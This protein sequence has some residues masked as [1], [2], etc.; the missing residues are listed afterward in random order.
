MILLL[1]GAFGVGKTTVA[2][3][4]AAS[5]PRSAI[6]DPELLGILLQRTAR[7]MG[8]TPDD[9][10]DLALWRTLTARGVRAMRTL[11][12]TV[13]V[14]MAFSNPAYLDEMR[15]RLARGGEDVLHCCLVAPLDVVEDR[16]RRRGADRARNA[17]EFRR[18][19]E[20]C[21]AHTTAAFAIHVDA[22][23]DPRSVAESVVAIV[24][25]STG[26][27]RPAP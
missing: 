9:F 15:G 8:R 3:L 11:A 12:D 23:G 20:C 7:L 26:S 1:N 5:L 6:Y 10:Q 25:T 27:A 19:A 18:A 17:W 21:V 16:L 2:R 13:V 24:H 22:T 14:P 4:V